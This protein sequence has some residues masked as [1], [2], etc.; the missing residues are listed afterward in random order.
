MMDDM[1]TELAT[2]LKPFASLLHDQ[3]PPSMDVV[4]PSYRVDM[5]LLKG[6]CQTHPANQATMSLV[7]VDNPTKAGD[8]ISNM[9]HQL[10]ICKPVIIRV[11]PVREEDK[12]T[13]LFKPIT[14]MLILLLH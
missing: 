10:S 3:P 4:V 14:T 12:Q 6:I 13:Y 1:V 7:V 2:H 5:K 9:Q 8:T 11:N